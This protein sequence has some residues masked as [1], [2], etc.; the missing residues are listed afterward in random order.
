[1]T[2]QFLHCPYIITGLQKMRRERV[3]KC[4][5]ARALRYS[6][7]R[8][9]PLYCSLQ[10]RLIDMMASSSPRRHIDILPSRWEYPVPAPIPRGAGSL[11][12]E[13]MRE[14]Y[15]V[16]TSNEIEPEDFP[17]ALQMRRQLLF[18]RGRA[19]ASLGRKIGEET[20]YVTPAKL[21]RVPHPVEPDVA[22]DPVDIRLFR[23]PAVVTHENRRS[24]TVEQPRLTR[25]GPWG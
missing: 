7:V 23:P 19:H 18:L 21:S 1:M 5:T 6:R 15:A 20:L 4:V 12:I 16:A 11:P 17:N 22:L 8:H 9:T 25:L 2:Q 13:C 10:H 3:A 24:D 14:T